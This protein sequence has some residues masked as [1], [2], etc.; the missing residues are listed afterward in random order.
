M[1]F[2][3]TVTN[4]HHFY[5]LIKGTDMR[6]RRL[7]AVFWTTCIIAF[8]LILYVMT[9]LSFKLPNIKPAVG[10]LDESK[11][12]SFESKLR[13]IENELNQHHA[14]VGEIKSAV[15]QIVEQ[16]QEYHPPQKRPKDIPRV[17]KVREYN[18]VGDEPPRMHPRLNVTTCPIQQ[19]V[20]L[21][22]DVQMLSMY[23]RILFD[24]KD[25]GVWKQGWNIEYS[26]SQWN[27]KNKLK[28]F[29]VPHS[30]NDPGWL[31]TFENY[32]KSQTKAI[33]NNMVEKLL[34]GSGRKFIW[35]EIS[36]L[37]L[38]WNS[39]ATDKDKA[40]FKDLLKTGQL[41]IVTGGWVMNDEA[42]SHWLSIIQQLTTGHQWLIDNI[43]YTPKNGWAIDPFGYS[44]TQPYLLK[45]AGF[46]NTLIQ[47]VH[48]RMK[49][50]L[51][52]N[53]QLEFR[54]RQVWDGVGNTDMFTH[55]M[56][57]YSY[58]IPHSCGPDPKICCQFD[59]KRLPGNGVT[60]PW[61]IA[62]RKIIQKNVQERSSLIL[63]QWK[64]KA[65]L[66]RSNVLMFPLGDDFRYDRSNEWDNQ[67]QNYEKII[68]F[69][70]NK[71]DWNTEVQFGTLQDYF[72]AVHEEVKLTD[73]PVLSGDFFT[74][75]D[76]NEHYWSG[77]YTSRP[78]YKNMDRVLLAYLRAAEIITAQA[79]VTRS[80]SYIISL[81]LRD[82]VEQ[83][84]RM[85]SLFQHH[86]G[87]TGT[88]RDEVREDYAKKLL[89]SIKYCQSAIQQAA[90]YLLKQPPIQ[91][92]TQEDIYFDVDD[93]W[94]R[95]DEVPSRI[96]IALDEMSPSR[97]L[98]LYNA[99]S[100]RRQEILTV[101]VS[102]PH[103]EV[104][105]PEGYPIM[106]QISPVVSGDKRLGF[107]ANKYQLSFPVTV[108]P[109][110]LTVYTVSLRDSMSINKHT[111]YSRVRVYNADYLTIDLPKMFAIEQPTSRLMDDI[112]IRA[113][114]GT[115]LVANLNGLI[116][117]VVSP[118]GVTVPV[119]MD[120]AQYGTRKE[121]DNNSGAYLFMPDGPA[122]EFK[123]DPFPEMVVTEGIYKATLYTALIGPKK[124]DIVLAIS[125]YDNPSL[126][127]S[128]VEISNMFLIDTQVDDM[129]LA[130]RFSTGV[131]NGDVFYTD[132]N[133]MQMVKRRYFDK[134]PLQANF[135]PL[136]AA[137]YIEDDE[138][139]F[140]VL[141]ST[142]LGMAALQPGQIEVMQDRRL[143]R[144]DNRG[145]NQGVLDNI[146]TRHTFRI[147]LEK[148]KKDCQSK[149]PPE[150]L[151]GE[152][153]LGAHVSQQ[154]LL[155]PIVTMH[156]TSHEDHHRPY[157]SHGKYNAADVVLASFHSHIA[158]KNKDGVPIRGMGMTFQ[159][160]SLDTC[161]GNKE[162][163]K[164]Y[165][166][167]DGVIPLKDL[168]EIEAD[169]VYDSSLTY[170]H[171]KSPVPDG[172][173]TLCQM[174]IRS[175]FIN[176]TL[177]NG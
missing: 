3:V 27:Q 163:S 23:E 108:D 133:G 55:M 113:G 11:W 72:K 177:R 79:T 155:Q 74:Y 103:V 64:K 130:I 164:S 95:H 118:D 78:F 5:E 170:V 121:K 45:L 68:D 9:D 36:Y 147:I 160:V 43:G 159:R 153:T 175:L 131:K 21:K 169:K 66:Y 34:E 174:E 19:H 59:F 157:Y 107:A 90:Y 161:Y 10:D 162:I 82:R 96:T 173:V 53:R 125:V 31:K 176:Q 151:S 149:F 94:R 122:R 144:D 7:S 114:N 100:F 154:L 167:S 51:A 38:W 13:H 85:L 29:I 139:R 84:R 89:T 47:R 98:V 127:Q 150:K 128:E 140:T 83:A 14:V 143:S 129:E 69:I 86:D 137:A 42:N 168:V 8:I 148:P 91:D 75:S 142:P 58:D 81:Q 117:A 28:V 44:S 17:P 57:F 20:T 35:A 4:N 37:S 52:S 39:D 80:V 12:S 2:T 132:L 119:H 135:Y 16:S 49:K 46:E 40:I 30:H 56:P 61:G 115:R 104:F 116:K 124:A 33:F 136:P 166:V 1:A 156:Y 97:R 138:M 70:N 158:A 120:F 71:D 134:L 110:A 76:R 50:E 102:S 77:Y 99:L 22:S 48:Y 112:N 54:W 60:C 63:D 109:L 93:I 15:D 41:E 25:G 123:T 26:D 141:T 172:V 62:P 146:R 87:I 18:I 145:M 165:P 73:F 152:L 65:Q 171:I 32:Y 111:S 105:D 126:P 106:A 92:Q 101:L 67:Y 6:I 24:D 88:S